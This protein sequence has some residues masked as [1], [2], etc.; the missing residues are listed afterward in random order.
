MLLQVPAWLAATHTQPPTYL[1][2]FVVYSLYSFGFN[3]TCAPVGV[4]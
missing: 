3:L 1:V 4:W 2:P